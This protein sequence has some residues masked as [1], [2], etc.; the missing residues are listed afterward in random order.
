MNN[1]VQRG[2]VLR[3]ITSPWTRPARA[4]HIN[5][6]LQAEP[7]SSSG[8]GTA[9]PGKKGPNARFMSCCFKL[10]A[11]AISTGYSVCF[12]INALAFGSL[13]SAPLNL[14]PEEGVD[15]IFIFLILLFFKEY[16]CSKTER[17]QTWLGALSNA[18]QKVR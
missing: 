8:E 2:Q 3:S 4:H 16:G 5:G 1:G 7:W 17:I 13:H 12:S 11:S 14:L 9:P 6:T 10:S 15:F 18:L